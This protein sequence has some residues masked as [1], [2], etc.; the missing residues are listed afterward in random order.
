MNL[1]KTYFITVENYSQVN[2]TPSTP[3][4]RKNKNRFLKKVK[5]GILT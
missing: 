2:M 5:E 4:M 1:L 3:E